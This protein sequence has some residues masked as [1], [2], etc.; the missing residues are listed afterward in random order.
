MWAS[1][2]A[3]SMTVVHIA[4]RLLFGTQGLELP[5]LVG[6]Y[7]WEYYR[8]IGTVRHHATDLLESFGL[9]HRLRHRP[10]ELSGGE[11]QR[12]AIARALM[13]EPKVLLADEPTGNLDEK[14]GAEI[15]DLIA[16]Q[17][18]KGLTIVMVTHDPAIAERADRIVRLHDG[19][20]EK[21]D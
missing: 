20:I 16:Q 11:R 10:R 3:G 17:H 15:L 9:G 8:R 1:G 18:R 6:M 21:R 4:V 2:Y 13:N 14:T 5:A 12:V 19:R 7:R